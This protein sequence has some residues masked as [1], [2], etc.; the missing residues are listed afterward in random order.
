MSE[1]ILASAS[2]RRRDM[3]AR[4]VERYEIRPADIDETPRPGEAPDAYVRRLACE[5]AQAIGAGRPSATV[6]G[7]DTIVVLDGELLG[8]PR[9]EEAALQMVSR[10]CGRTHSVLTGVAWVRGGEVVEADVVES[11]V[12]LREASELELR[13]YVATGEPMDKAGGYAIQ[14]EAGSFVDRV[15]GSVTNVI[16]LPLDQTEAM[17]RRVGIPAPQGG[18]DAEAIGRR[19]RAV[20]GEIQARAVASGREPDAVRLLSVVKGL[21]SQAAQAVVDAGARDLA[22]NYVQEAVAKRGAVG[23][24][25]RWHLIGPLQSNKAG[26]AISTFDSV[27]T[28]AKLSTAR[29]LSRRLA[30]DAELSVLLQV[31]IT[32]DPAKAGVA[33]EEL[34]TLALEVGAL[35]GLRVDGLMTVPRQGLDAAESAAAFAELRQR[36]EDMRLRER[37]QGSELSMGMSGDYG[38]AIAEGSTQVRLGTA[39]LGKRP[40]SGE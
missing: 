37:L 31:N 18:L 30:D 25:V 22:E 4:I 36:C 11:R 19:F 23:N 35:R 15:S 16:G 10:L 14:G 27:Q 26:A 13:R 29:A 40:G 17:A 5:K 7:S 33:A 1:V 38:V 2:P 6:L 39:I 28:I 9:D 20:A 24:G 3:L 32:G 12:H 21:P 34:E 8:K